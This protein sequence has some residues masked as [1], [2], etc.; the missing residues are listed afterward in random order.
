MVEAILVSWEHGDPSNPRNWSP[1]YKW[2]LTFQL[3]MLALTASMG[4][5]IVAPS[6][7]SIAQMTGVTA[8]VS[9]LCISLYILGFAFGPLLWAPISE[10]WGRRWGMLPAMAGL[11]VFSIGTATSQN[12]Q[13]ILVTRCIAGVFGSAPVSNVSAALGDIWAPDQ[14]GLA[15]AFYAVAVVGGPTLGPVIGSAIT[16]PLGWR[17]TEYIQAIW[18]FAILI[19][20]VLCLPE[21]YSPVLLKIKA[22]KLRKDT[23]DDRYFHPH[24]HTKIEPK[25]IITKHFS[26]P[27]MM[28]VAE[29]VVTAIACYA[30]FVYGMLYMTLEV[31]PLVYYEH[32]GWS[33]LISNLPFL[34]LFVGVLCAV[35]INVANQPR[36]TRISKAA[37]GKPVPEARLLPMAVGGILFAVGIWIFAWTADPPVQWIVSA[38]AAAFFGAGFS[39]TFNQ[40]VNFLVD[41]YQLYA[42][43]AIAAN[44]ILRSVFAAGLPLLARPMIYHLGTGPAMSILGALATVAVPIPFL[45]MKYAAALRRR[46]KFANPDS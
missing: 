42:A 41:T 14:R 24:E 36:Y 17:W 2:W 4:S 29:P 6:E 27:L 23:G 31:F 37:G 28:L 8:E 26:R 40:C 39:V 19:L 43:S 22:Q 5:S 12:I 32:R 18:T 16:A 44:T 3:G 10:L 34:A 45:F 11:G 33:L 7:M 46:S 21:S 30:S 15:V 1:A 25:S 35:F 9:V 20:C 38:I 13:S